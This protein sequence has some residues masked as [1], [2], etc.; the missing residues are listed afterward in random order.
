M[1]KLDILHKTE[2]DGG[3]DRRKKL[4]VLM[5]EGRRL[6]CRLEVGGGQ[7]GGINFRYG[8]L[9]YAV[10]DIN[11]KGEVKL[12][13]QPHPTRSAPPELSKALNGY[14][15]QAAGLDPKTFPISSYGY[16]KTKL[17]DVPIEDLMAW[18]H[19]SI[20][21]IRGTYYASIHVA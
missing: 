6:G 11:T 21:Q 19:T 5:M 4:E 3:T 17:E 14:I 9:L 8:S 7:A 20:D 1:D 15:E 16:L 12:Y 2:A 10:M 18:L 13:V